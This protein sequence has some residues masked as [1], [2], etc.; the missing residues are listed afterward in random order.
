MCVNERS[1]SLRGGVCVNEQTQVETKRG[2]NRSRDS[3]HADTIQFVELPSLSPWL[4][5]CCP[6]L[7]S[8]LTEILGMSVS[9][10]WAEWRKEGMKSWQRMEEWRNDL[11]MGGKDPNLAAAD[12]WLYLTEI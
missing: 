9:S 1:T 8:M 3:V 10:F 12:E 5:P 6:L 2:R 7:H 11:N 4:P